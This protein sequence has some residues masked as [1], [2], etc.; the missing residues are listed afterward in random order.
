MLLKHLDTVI[1]FT[2][3]MLGISLAITVLT[4]MFVAMTGLRG[5]NLRWGLERLLPALAETFHLDIDPKTKTLEILHHP[6]IS[7]SAFSAFA[8]RLPRIARLV[9]RSEERRVGKECRL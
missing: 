7:D 2:V 5:T 8:D 1:A 9:N 6:L 4:Q 3:V